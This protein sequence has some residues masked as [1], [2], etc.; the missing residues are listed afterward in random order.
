MNGSFWSNTYRQ[1][2]VYITIFH[3]KLPN[4]TPKGWFQLGRG[5]GSAN[6]SSEILFYSK[7]LHIL[8]YFVH[9]LHILEAVLEGHS[10]LQ[11]R[12]FNFNIF[13]FI[14]AIGFALSWSDA[15]GELP[16]VLY[17]VDFELLISGNVILQ[18]S[19]KELATD[20]EAIKK[21]I[22]GTAE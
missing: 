2:R 17:F 13:F 12:D 20:I 15:T 10:T 14:S 5:P 1:T 3:T 9:I 16:V 4:N 7:C 18:S 6:I 8:I 22:A 19:R 11:W 21:K